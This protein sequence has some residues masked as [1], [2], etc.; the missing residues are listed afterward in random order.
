MAKRYVIVTRSFGAEVEKPDISSLA[1]W[2]P[3]RKG[4]AGDLMTILLE[5]SLHTQ[6]E[7]D[8]PCGGG[9]FYRERLLET[10][11]GI[12]GDALTHEPDVNPAHV[13][14]DAVSLLSYNRNTWCALPAPSM[15][16]ISNRYYRD[17]AEFFEGLVSAYSDLMRTMRNAG[18]KG[19]VL[20]S[21][22]PEEIELEELAGRRA[23]FFLLDP[24]QQS[25]ATLLEHQREIAIP[26]S[27]FDSVL[28]LMGEFAV[29]KVALL[30]PA[31]GD[32]EQA[33]LHMDIENLQAGGYCREECAAYWETLSEQAYVIK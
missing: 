17:S 29:Q 22:Q 6:G 7:I 25:I 21:R 14:M 4:R 19:H 2:L 31:R 15:L 8:L 1:A 27:L 11:G 3:Q 30:D 20:I 5:L 24:D 26:P 10:I 23:L 18:I 28:G 16:D 32:L 9:L 13:V 12:E 33:A